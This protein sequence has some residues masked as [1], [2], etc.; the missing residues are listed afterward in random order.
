MPHL[1]TFFSFCHR[2]KRYILWPKEWFVGLVIPQVFH[3]FR[4]CKKRLKHKVSQNC[5]VVDFSFLFFNSYGY[6]SNII[7]F[8]R[9]Q[10]NDG[11]IVHCRRRREREIGCVSF[12]AAAMQSLVAQSLPT[13]QI[14]WFFAIIAENWVS[15]NSKV[16]VD[17]WH[18]SWPANE[19]SYEDVHCSQQKPIGAW[20][21]F[22]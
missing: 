10:C 17:D 11:K 18:V 21:R 16:K 3:F 2:T 20:A 19:K 13:F 9:R 7:L 1:S 22:H 4:P 6:T 12:S 15:W 5:F 14:I 8:W